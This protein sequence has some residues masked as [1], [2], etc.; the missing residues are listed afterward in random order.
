MQTSIDSTTSGSSTTN[1]PV[2]TTP[3]PAEPEARF[4]AADLEK[5]RRE[6]KDKVYGRLDEVAEQNKTLQ[7]Q[8]ADL[9]A[10]STARKEAEEAARRE[11]EEAAQKAAEAEL[12]ARDLI[13]KRE[14]ELAERLSQT[15]NEWEQ[16]FQQIAA[17]REQERAMAEKEREM[18]TLIAYTQQ[19]V[20]EEADNIAP[21]LR[22]FIGGNTQA[23][24]DASIERVKAKSA[25]IVGAMQETLQQQRSVQRGVS[26]TGYAPVGPLEGVGGQRQYSAEDIRGMSIEEYAKFRQQAGIAGSTAPRGLFS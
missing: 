18:A 23:E 2:F 3:P 6:E 22:D 26:P 7:A 19:R 24:I 25:E 17:E 16:K 13:A 12:S 1:G 5:A 11:A 8:L 10:E 9:L 4:T 21:Q 20:A 14:A 15:T